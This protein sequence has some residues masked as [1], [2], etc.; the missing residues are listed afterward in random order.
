MELLL[1]CGNNRERQLWEVEKGQA[2]WKGLVTLDCDAACK[3]DVVFDLD[4]V[5]YFGLPFEPE[6][7]EEIHAYNVLEHVGK[8]GDWRH[9]FIEF[10]EYW[11]VLKPGGRF[12]I[13]VPSWKSEWAWGDPGHTR[14]LTPGTFY[15]LDQDNYTKLG[16]TAMTDYRGQWKCDFKTIYSSTDENHTYIILEKH[17]SKSI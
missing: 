17:V 8:Q 10:E 15:F 3:P 14:V 7:F 4:T 11:R 5:S 9:F 12:Y 16:N 6:K 2:P 13:V 1:G